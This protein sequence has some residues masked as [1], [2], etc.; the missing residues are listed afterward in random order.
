MEVDLRG[1]FSLDP[2]QTDALDAFISGRLFEASVWDSPRTSDGIEHVR[3][4]EYRPDRVRVCGRI[5][6]IDQSLHSFW[7][8]LEREGSGIGVTWS[9]YFDVVA[10]S[11]RRRRNAIDTYDHAN[12]I[13]WRVALAGNAE[14]RDGALV[15]TSADS[16]LERPH[17]P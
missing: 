16:V 5:F 15:V 11:P 10:N 6:Q 3:L 1:V 17:N 2:G 8:D 13:D 9:L 7:L 14:V 4:V 12:E